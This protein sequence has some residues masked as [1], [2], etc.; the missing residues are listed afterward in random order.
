MCRLHRGGPSNMLIN[1]C[2][3]IAY[4]WL[5]G[6][7]SIFVTQLPG[8]TAVLIEGTQTF[9]MAAVGL[10]VCITKQWTWYILVFDDWSSSLTLAPGRFEWHFRDV[11]FKL[12]SVIDG[13]SISCEIALRLLSL[14]FT[15]DKSTLVQVMAWCRQ[16]TTLC[17]LDLYP[18]TFTFC[19]NITV[20]ISDN[21]WK[22]HDDMMTGTLSKRSGRQTD[23]RTDGLKCT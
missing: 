16:A 17:D 6:Q 22:F 3:K 14:E 15:D 21:S 13:W 4:R 1:A 8:V 18:L 20:V 10:I 12:I 19:M 11:M 7:K 23:G 9:H 5:H 2:I